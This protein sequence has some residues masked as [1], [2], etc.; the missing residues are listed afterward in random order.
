[1]TQENAQEIQRKEK[2]VEEQEEEQREENIRENGPGDWLLWS[3]V[4][5]QLM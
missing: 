1:M 3:V 2:S 4:M 5:I